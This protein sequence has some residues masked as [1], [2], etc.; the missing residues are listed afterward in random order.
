MMRS[1]FGVTGFMSQSEMVALN[2]L[3]SRKIGETTIREKIKSLNKKVMIGVL[4]NKNTL[5]GFLPS[6][7]SRYPLIED[8][9][10]IFISDDLFLNAV[11]YNSDDWRMLSQQLCK[12]AETFENLNAIQLNLAWPDSEHIIR[13]R[14]QFPNIEIIL[15]VGSSAFYEVGNSPRSLYARLE[16]YSKC[17]NHVLF[18]MSGGGGKLIDVNNELIKIVVDLHAKFPQMSIGIAGGLCSSA[19]LGEQYQTKE[20]DGT[21]KSQVGDGINRLTE[22]LSSSESDLSR[23]SLDAEAKLRIDDALY[24]PEV[25]KYLI[26]S[27][28]TFS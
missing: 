27:I 25:I 19:L 18:D 28:A 23:L 11:H 2:E 14:D 5:M 16:E 6:N 20:P 24:L 3:L 12:I 10:S 4:V 17:I 13:F 9:K 15:Q 26:A 21:T 22:C 7:P 1:Y 8:A